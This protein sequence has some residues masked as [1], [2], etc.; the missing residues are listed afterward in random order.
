MKFRSYVWNRRPSSLLGKSE[1]WKQS[2][3][4]NA[5]FFL[6]WSYI[7]SR[8]KGRP[9]KKT[10]SDQLQRSWLVYVT[11]KLTSSPYLENY[12]KTADIR[13]VFLTNI[14]KVPK[15]EQSTKKSRSMYLYV[16]G[17]GRVD[18]DALSDE[19]PHIGSQVVDLWQICSTGLKRRIL[20]YRIGM[21]L[22][23]SFLMWATV[24]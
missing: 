3:K 20:C 16:W 24:S 13:L 23:L 6:G 2:L 22:E 15:F 1:S 8:A 4:Y 21:A 9:Y 12:W 5:N 18:G 19:Y 14:S 11:N 7:S 17:V 10:F